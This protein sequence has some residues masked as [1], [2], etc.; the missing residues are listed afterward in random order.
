MAHSF[1]VSGSRTGEAFPQIVV[2]WFWASAK[3]NVA[4]DRSPSKC[5]SDFGNL[6]FKS[7]V[8]FLGG[9]LCPKNAQKNSVLLARGNSVAS[10]R[11]ANY[12]NLGG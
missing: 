7:G 11:G 6:P 12:L 1:G 8:S 4:E 5:R 2:S 9:R 10:T 3:I